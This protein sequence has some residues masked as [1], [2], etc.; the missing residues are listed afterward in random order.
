MTAVAAT[1]AWL[2][3]REPPR[4]ACISLSVAPLISAS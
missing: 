2:A 1:D 3:A 4:R